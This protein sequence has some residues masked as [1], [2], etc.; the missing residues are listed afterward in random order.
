MGE[1][2]AQVCNLELYEVL[3]VCLANLNVFEN[4]AVLQ[5]GEN[6]FM[7]GSADEVYKIAPF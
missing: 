7:I 3:T 2:K 4:M 1:G 6:H 5:S